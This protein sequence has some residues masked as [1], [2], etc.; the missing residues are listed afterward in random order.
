MALTEE[1]IAE[2]P[3]AWTDAEGTVWAT[4]IELVD[5][6]RLKDRAQVDLFDESCFELLYGASPLPRLEIMA[7]LYRPHWEAHELVYTDFVSRVMGSEAIHEAALAAFFAGL[8][9]FFRRCG[10]ADL[11]ALIDQS[12]ETLKATAGQR[13]DVA[14][15]ERVRKLMRDAIAVTRR[16]MENQLD[17]AAAELHSQS[18]DRS[19]NSRQS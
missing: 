17:K 6:L 1:K 9:D 2:S 3:L 7:E 10:R 5:V 11:A 8:A 18:G 15:G 13:T 16:E 14:T 12:L 4:R 19:L